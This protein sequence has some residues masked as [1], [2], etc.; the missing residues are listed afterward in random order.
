MIPFLM[1]NDDANDEEDEGAESQSED[2]D[3]ADDRLSALYLKGKSK[4]Q[5]IVYIS[6]PNGFHVELAR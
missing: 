3:E 6:Q 1:L 5:R 4:R 2:E